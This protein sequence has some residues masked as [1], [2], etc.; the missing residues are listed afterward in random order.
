MG[1]QRTVNPGAEPGRDPPTQRRDPA[2]RRLA[3]VLPGHQLAAEQLADRRFRHLAHEDV[4]AR[5]LEVGERRA[6]APF[7]ERSRVERARA[8]DEGDDALAPALVG[9]ADDG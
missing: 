2:L 6:A 3:L 5:A 8:P 9:E 7:V 1:H 4:L